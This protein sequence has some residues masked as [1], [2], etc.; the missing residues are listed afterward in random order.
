MKRVL[1]LDDERRIATSVAR[2]LKDLCLVD[3]FVD[4]R[5]ALKALQTN[6]YDCILSDVDMPNMSGIEF[7]RH[8]SQDHPALQ[9]HFI[10][11]TGSSKK[12]PEGVCW[13]QKGVEPNTL[14]KLV[15]SLIY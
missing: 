15:M 3:I 8:V 10:F 1:V 2:L 9:S 4:G 7:Y 13:V 14:Q 5:E 6:S 12:I 11:H